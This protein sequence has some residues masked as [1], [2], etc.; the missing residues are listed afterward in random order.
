MT[1]KNAFAALCLT[2]PLVAF[3]APPAKDQAVLDKGKASFNVNCAACHGEKGDGTGPAAAALNPKPRNFATDPFKQGDKLEDVF[4]TAT[5][6]VPS[7]AMVAF[8]HIPEAERWALA[9]WVLELRGKGP[10]GAAAAPAP[11][12][13]PAK[14]PA[15][16]EPTKKK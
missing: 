15:K 3:A 16:K 4:K 9:Y 5:A 10:A 8:A 6:G 2:A 14:E 7:T 12:K 1:L 13:E 11:A